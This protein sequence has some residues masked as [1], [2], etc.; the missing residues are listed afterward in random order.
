[1]STVPV[2]PAT[3]LTG[4]LTLFGRSGKYLVSGGELQ[5]S[6]KIVLQGRQYF[7]TLFP[8]ACGHAHPSLLNRSQALECHG[9]LRTATIFPLDMP[10]LF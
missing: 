2:H 8:R 3:H 10:L 5:K 9:L 7:H 6:S 1:M 4:I